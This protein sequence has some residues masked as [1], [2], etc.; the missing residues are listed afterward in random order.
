METHPS[1]HPGKWSPSEHPSPGLPQPSLPWHLDEQLE[2]GDLGHGGELLLQG[3][4]PGE[5]FKAPW[6]PALPRPG[7]A[8]TESPKQAGRQMRLVGLIVQ[9]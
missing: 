8:P 6:A 1:A 3:R 4:G 5:L 9:A 7:P 2:L